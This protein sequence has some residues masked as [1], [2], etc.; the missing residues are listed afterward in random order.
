VLSA[1][2]QQEGLGSLQVL[3]DLLAREGPPG[4]AAG[5]TARVLSIAPGCALSWALYETFKQWMAARAAA[6]GP[7]KR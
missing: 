4:L 3:R 1:T 6:A 7:G 5:L 2:R